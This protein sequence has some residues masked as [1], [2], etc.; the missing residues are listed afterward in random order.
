MCWGVP[1]KVI[2]IDGFTALVDFG[3]VKKEV[4]V[5]TSKISPNDLVMIHAGMVIN[6]LS[7]E[8]FMANVALYRDILSQELVDEGLDEKTAKRNATNEINK[9]LVSLGIHKPV[10]EIDV[11]ETKTMQA[12]QKEIHVPGNAF[13]KRYRIPLSDTDYLQVMH[14]TNYFRYCERA[15]QEL[16]ENLGFGY[17]TLIHKFGLFVPTVETSGKI[18]G[19]VR[20]DNEIEVAVWVEEV[21][22]KHIKFRN[23]IKN[24]T[25]GKVVAECSTVS[26][27]T[28]TTLMESMT[29][30]VEL[31]EGLKKYVARHD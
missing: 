29:L 13:R 21:G 24:F 20:L 14:Y 27:C 18:L 15:Q 16:L 8:D 9:L 26:V 1:A 6:K 3:G 12:P 19:P 28:D 30:P 17:A 31:A 7:L 23:I 22:R 25:S 10:P 11:E 5:A 2:S 4:I